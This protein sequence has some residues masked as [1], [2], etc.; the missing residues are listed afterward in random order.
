MATAGVPW[1]IPC[2]LPMTVTSYGGPRDAFSRIVETFERRGDIVFV[3]RTVHV[4]GALDRVRIQG[5]ITV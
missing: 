1:P 4:R 2:C 5:A 3:H